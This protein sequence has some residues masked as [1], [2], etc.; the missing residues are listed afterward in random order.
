[1]KKGNITIHFPAFDD[2]LKP[3]TAKKN[4]RL[5]TNQG[6]GATLEE[7]GVIVVNDSSLDIR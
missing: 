1:M 4:K 3:A 6:E 5:R 2:E 7:D